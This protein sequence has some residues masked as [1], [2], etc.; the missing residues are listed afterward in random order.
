M[1]TARRNGFTLVEVIIVVSIISLL[2]AG[3]I[4]SFSNYTKSQTL[5]QAQEQ[6]V[7]DLAN[8]QNR[9]LAGEQGAGV[10]NTKYWGLRF[11][12]GSSTYQ[13][14]AH[15]TATCPSSAPNIQRSQTLT[16]DVEVDIPANGCVFF[17][18][19]NGDATGLSS[20]NIKESGS[21]TCRKIN[22]N[23]AGLITK[24]ACP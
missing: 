1:Q 22:I 6:I 4:P 14:F 12:D 11:V 8:V 19:A 21:S 7:S 2:T 24:V 17:S 9:A 10:T 18:T 20:I 13:Y 23:S 16:G 5:K 3:L 15:T